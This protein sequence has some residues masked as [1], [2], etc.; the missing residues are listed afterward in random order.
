MYKITMSSYIWLVVPC[1]IFII[2]FYH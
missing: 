2:S 1:R